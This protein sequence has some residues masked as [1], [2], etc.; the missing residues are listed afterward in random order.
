MLI[1]QC[2]RSFYETKHIIVV[3][4]LIIHTALRDDDLAYL[5]GTNTKDLH[6]I[7]GK[8]REDRF[9]AVHT[10]QELKEGQQRPI[11]RTYYYIDYRATI[12]A[13]KWRVYTINKQV[14]GVAVPRDEIKEFRCQRCKAEWTLMDV[15]ERPAPNSLGFLCR[16]CGFLL[17]AME[18]TEQGG[19]EQSTKLNAQ[20]RFITE[21]LPKLD[22][23]II[24][25]SIAE[26]ALESARKINRDESNPAYDSLPVTTA[27]ARPTAV[28]GLINTGP[29]SIAVTLTTSEGPTDADVAAEQARKEKV[30]KQNA[31]PVHFTH[32]TVTGEQVKFGAPTTTTSSIKLEDKKTST[33]DGDSLDADTAE[34]DDYFANLKAQQARDALIAEEE[35]EETDD[36][37]EFEDA[38]PL[39]TSVS[40]SQKSPSKDNTLGLRPGPAKQ[41]G[42]SGSSTGL[43]SPATGVASEGEEE[44][45]RA[46]KRSKTDGQMAVKQE[47]EVESEEDMEFE[48]V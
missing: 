42:E 22:Q 44:G 7:A 12:D 35:E 40:A 37:D 47:D 27:Y 8:L 34:I 43:T 28:K 13:I 46:A 1:R 5:M 4:A 15:L 9:L 26:E 29:T 24:P 30:A 21:M 36:D 11:S 20:F 45:D 33:P 16:V 2:V 17:E 38:M 19:H 41:S 23:V 39:E 32:S 6:K 10:R 31:M 48:D 3:D 25:E 18:N 14:Q